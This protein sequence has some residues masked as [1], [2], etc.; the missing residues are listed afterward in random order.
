MVKDVLIILGGNNPNSKLWSKNMKKYFGKKYKILLFYYDHRK[1]S[2][3]DIDFEVEEKRLINFIKSKKLNN[4]SILAKSAGFLLSLKLANKSYFYPKKIIGY[5]LPI[6]YSNYRKIHLKNL[7]QDLNSKTDILCI[8]ANKDP[9][10]SAQEVQILVEQ[11]FPIRIYQ[12][13]T[14]NYDDFKQMSN[15]ASSFILGNQVQNTKIKRVINPIHMSDIIRIVHK[16]RNKNKYKFQ[17]HWNF[18][19]KWKLYII[20]YG[21]KKLFLKKWLISDLEKEKKLTCKVRNLINN[22]QVLSKKIK[23]IVPQLYCI[24]S[25]VGYLVSEYLWP[26]CNEMFY[27]ESHKNLSKLEFMEI[28]KI[29][30]EFSISPHNFLPRNT[31]IKNNTIFLID[32]E[33][34]KPIKDV[35][36]LLYQASLLLGRGEVLWVTKK[37]IISSFSTNSWG[38]IPKNL[39]KYEKVF[40]NMTGLFD[41]NNYE[42]QQKCYQIIFSLSSYKSSFWFLKIDDVLHSLSGIFPIEVEILIDFLLYKEMIDNKYYL[43]KG[44]SNIIKIVK[45]QITMGLP[46]KNIKVFLIWEVKKII[47][48]SIQNNNLWLLEYIKKIIKL[49]YPLWNSSSDFLNEIENFLWC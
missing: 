27:S 5:G 33:D 12:D 38:S 43:Y 42:I 1:H 48:T 36:T 28:L 46:K 18:D 34:F 32:R 22:R 47:L 8:Q 15:I 45:L 7:I 37:D 9:Q 10:W 17:N 40:K 29:F 20:S 6:K 2:R 31:I 25:K 13:H 19:I 35:S 4:Y 24:N 41:S 23:I 49:E 14:H 3:E 16:N 39:T 26:D 11:Q 30:N 44:L 21:D